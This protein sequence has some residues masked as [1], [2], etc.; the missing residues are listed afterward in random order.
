MECPKNYNLCE[1]VVSQVTKTENCVKELLARKSVDVDHIVYSYSKS[2]IFQNFKA[3]LEKSLC[4]QNVST[5]F[6][7]SFY[8]PTIF[9]FFFPRT[10]DFF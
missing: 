5:R 2:K 7:K 8:I 6:S 3:D 4:D 9:K 1:Y 10:F